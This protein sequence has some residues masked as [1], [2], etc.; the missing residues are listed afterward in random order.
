[1]RAEVSGTTYPGMC[2][3]GIR[4]TFDG[5]SRTIEVHILSDEIEDIYGEMVRI[6]FISRVRDEVKFNSP[7]ELIEQLNK[8]K[9]ACA[10]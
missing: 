1:M 7:E 4:P 3:I 10:I 8:D 9:M 6:E 2:N 5:T